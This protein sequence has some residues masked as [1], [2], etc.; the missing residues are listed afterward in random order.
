MT[1]AGTNGAQDA[2]VE[3]VLDL[4]VL[5]R[6][7]TKP[8][9]P[10]RVGGQ[11]FTLSDPDSL[12]WQSQA[13]LDSE[14]LSRIFAALLGP[15]QF[16]RFEPILTPAWKLERLMRAW[17]S[18]YGIELPES[19]ASST[20]SAITARPSRPISASTTAPASPTSQAAV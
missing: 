17:G 15:E 8:P 7:T 9:F 6:D 1:G 4:D 19:E 11:D 5:E 12:D 13:E 16:A 14:D 3:D 2:Q 20:S 18:Y 10:F